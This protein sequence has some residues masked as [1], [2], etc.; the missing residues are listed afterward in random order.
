MLHH[1]KFCAY[2]TD[3][4]YDFKKH[5]STDR[6]KQQVKTIELEE[7]TKRRH[8]ERQEDREFLVKQCNK[9]HKK[10][11]KVQETA[12]AAK[13]YSKSC[14]ALLNSKF[15]DNPPLTYPGDEYCK[16]EIYK[17]FKLSEKDITTKFKLED[18]IL[19][20]YKKK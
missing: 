8:I 4:M 7:L 3:R 17:H 15:K 16:K 14:I 5:I 2:E 6:H 1:C 18:K 12:S 20:K 9:L 13:Q 10:I 19:D 11:N